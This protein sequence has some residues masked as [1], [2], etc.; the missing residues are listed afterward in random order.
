MVLLKHHLLGDHTAMEM[1]HREVTAHLRG[2]ADELPAR[3]AV[4][5][6]RRAGAAGRQ[7][8]RARGVLPRD[9]GRRRRADGAVRAGQRAGRRCERAQNVSRH[10][11]AARG[12]FARERARARRQHGQRVPRRMGARAGARV[13]PQRRRVRDGAVRP[14][15]GRRGRR[16]RARHVHEHAAGA[17][18]GRR[19]RRARQRQAGAPAAGAAAAPRARAAGARAA[20]QRRAG[21]HAAVQLAAELSPRRAQEERRR[22]TTPGRASRP[23]AARSART[24]RSRCRSTT[25]ATS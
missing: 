4:P 3:A 9:A 22:E 12:A 23:K 18:R 7:P 15:A 6:L 17:H 1:M 24:I 21:V 5:Q 2:A 13:G 19:A 11:R 10:R 14:H 25:T 20:L 16:Q 8:R